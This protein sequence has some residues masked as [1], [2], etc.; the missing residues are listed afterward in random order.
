MINMTFQLTTMPK[1]DTTLSPAV[2]F[3]RLLSRYACG[4]QQCAFL[5]SLSELA[6]FLQCSMVDV[7][8]ALQTLRQQ[9]YDF[10]IFGTDCPITIWYPNND[11]PVPRTAFGFN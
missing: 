5:P 11:Q 9:G 4:L 2:Y 8:A 10:F 6:N 7:H 3:E 1:A